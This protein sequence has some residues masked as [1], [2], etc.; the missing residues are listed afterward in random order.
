VDYAKIDENYKKVL[1]RIKNSE[2]ETNQSPPDGLS[3]S[4]RLP[5]KIEEVQEYLDDPHNTLA[6]NPLG[7]LYR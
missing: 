1:Q 5:N 2:T 4:I 7:Q 6:R 3:I